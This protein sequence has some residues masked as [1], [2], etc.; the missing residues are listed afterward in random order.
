[1]GDSLLLVGIFF[2]LE[3][4]AFLGGFLHSRDVQEENIVTTFLTLIFHLETLGILTPKFTGIAQ[5][6]QYYGRF[7]QEQVRAQGTKPTH[8]F[9]TP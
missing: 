1:M 3:T 5:T 6:S 2:F 8:I 9:N 4:F 7:V